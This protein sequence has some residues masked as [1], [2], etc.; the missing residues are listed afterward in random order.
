M[1]KNVSIKIQVVTGVR[2]DVH[3]SFSPSTAYAQPGDNIEWRSRW[4][5]TVHF[6]YGTPAGR[7]SLYAEDS[8][9]DYWIVS[10]L[11]SARARGR[12]RYSAGVNVGGKIQVG[13]SDSIIIE[14]P[15]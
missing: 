14:D 9:A 3:I 15:W 1:T 7:A 12:Y 5:F 8:G 2:K 6:P 4:P 11:V 13:H 10:S